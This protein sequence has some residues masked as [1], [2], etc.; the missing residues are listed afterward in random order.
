[1]SDTKQPT[2]TMETGPVLCGRCRRPL[3]PLVVEDIQGL[4][5]LRSDT[6][7]IQELKANCLHCG[8]TFRFHRKDDDAEK[9]TVIY[10]KLLKEITD[11]N[12]E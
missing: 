12:P 9:M 10:G 5:Q 3:N 1:M 4:L 7:I 2:V 8:W 6:V 11:Y